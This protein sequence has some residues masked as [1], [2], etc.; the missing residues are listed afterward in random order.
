MR[1]VSLII[2]LILF[3]PLAAVALAAGMAYWWLTGVEQI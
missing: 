1:V 2:V 3:G